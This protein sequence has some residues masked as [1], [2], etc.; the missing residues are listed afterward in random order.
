M[1]RWK[2]A[3]FLEEHVVYIFRVEENT[4]LLMAVKM[5]A[6]TFLRN[7]FPFNELYSVIF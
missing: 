3:D 1:S 6:N 2:S 7:F 4:S 5:E